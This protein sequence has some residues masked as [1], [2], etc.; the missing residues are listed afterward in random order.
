LKPQLK[1]KR[2][3]VP[4]RGKGGL[5]TAK[6]HGSRTRRKTGLYMRG[7]PEGEN[8]PFYGRD[9]EKFVNGEGR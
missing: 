1:E 8:P 6:E 3:H 9:P 4:G 5:K 7:L 2:R